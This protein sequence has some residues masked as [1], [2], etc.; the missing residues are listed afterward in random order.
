MRL[1]PKIPQL[2]REIAVKA[3]D[4]H[5][6]P[7]RRVDA[8]NIWTLDLS[9]EPSYGCCD[10]H[11]QFNRAGACHGQHWLSV[12]TTEGVW[13]RASQSGESFVTELIKGRAFQAGQVAELRR[14]FAFHT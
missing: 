13:K 1:H 3:C 6:S 12:R 8:G 9:Q 14:S 7:G 2:S 10:K 11:K 5:P 4:S